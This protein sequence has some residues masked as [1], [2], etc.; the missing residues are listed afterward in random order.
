M[1]HIVQVQAKSCLV[2]VHDNLM[3]SLANYDSNLV[4]ELGQARS[5]VHIMTADVSISKH[6]S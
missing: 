3:H 2:S 4:L 6:P 1:L 5:K